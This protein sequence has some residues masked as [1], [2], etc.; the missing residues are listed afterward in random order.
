LIEILV[1]I[2]IIG[3]ISAFIIVS[4]AGVS[5][6]AT[7][8]KGQ[9]FA[10]SL[11][12]SLLLNLVSEWKFEGPTAIDGTATT[13]DAKDSWGSNN[14]SSVSGNPAVKGGTNCISG[15]CIYFDGSGDSF[16]I[17]DSST[18]D[19]IFG[20]ENFTLEAWIFST[21]NVNYQG[22]INK[23]TS[24][25][26]SASPG[27]IFIESTGNNLQFVL[28]TGNEGETSDLVS[29]SIA[30]LHD[31]WLHV[32]GAAGNG[33]LKLYVNG[34]LVGTPAAITK[35]PPTNDEPMTI[36]SFY[37]TNRSFN[38]RIDG[39]RVYNN[40]MPTSLIKEN[41]YSGLNKLFKNNGITLN[42]FNQRVAELKSNSA[43]NE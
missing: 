16:S 27:G 17:P 5:E 3:I 36:G 43:D 18:L 2:V 4:M 1:V 9:A 39:V 22:I 35:N 30:N 23:R 14:A 8:A 12:N 32:V 33:Y 42:E 38:G 28:G 10:N 26:Y 41:Y 37:T 34:A 25:Y 11:K 21:L 20:T 29:Y 19:T 6:K 24:N 7:I 15:K 31:R 13:D 40:P